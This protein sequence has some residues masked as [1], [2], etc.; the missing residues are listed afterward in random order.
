MR[1]SSGV[2]RTLRFAQHLPKFGWRPVVLTIDPRAYAA[3]SASAGNEIPPDLEV[4]RTFG[5]DAARDLS[6]LGRYPRALA[7]P[8]R[9]ALWRLWAVRRARRIARAQTIDAIWST[10][11]IATAHRIGLDVER[12]TGVPWIAEF[13]DPM[14]QGDYPP[15]PRVNR[16]W[17]KLESRVFETAAAAVVVTPGAAATYRARFPQFRADRLVVIENGYDEDTFQRAQA[18]APRRRDV[19]SGRPITLLHSGIIYASERDP[20]QLFAA[21]ASLKRVGRISAAA[22]QVVLRASGSE[23]DYRAL[24]AEFDISDIV[25]LEPAIDYL[26]AV[27]EMLSADGLVILQAANCNEQVPAKLYEYLRAQRPILALTDA[28]GD[29]AR[30]LA[31]A[32][33]GFVAPLDSAPRIEEAL[34]GFVEAIKTNAWR[35]APADVIARY[36]REAQTGQLAQL[37]HR[38]T[39][40][41]QA[42]R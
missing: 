19:V 23:H 10:F 11:P 30:T 41:L 3:V 24:L 34:V 6:I 15:E 9:W 5:L 39:S 22:L 16:A 37:L 40:P 31:A 8:D 13:R 29:T 36:S 26:A 27:Q 28:A 32:G 20:T 12:H 7:L 18:S 38:V 17:R 4:H 2:Q 14:W 35:R 21:L 25:R 1:G 33:T 42:D